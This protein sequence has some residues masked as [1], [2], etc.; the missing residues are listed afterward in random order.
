M[1]KKDKK[2]QAWSKWCIYKHKYNNNCCQIKLGGKT[3]SRIDDE[4]SWGFRSRTNSGYIQFGPA[5]TS[6][7]HIY[8][9]QQT[10]ILIK[11]C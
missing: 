11:S 8:T 5:N 10:S 9:D 7:A 2:V 6:H 3:D 1:D 4:G